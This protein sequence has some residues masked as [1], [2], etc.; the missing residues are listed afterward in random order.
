MIAFEIGSKAIRKR[1]LSAQEEVC[2]QELPKDE[3]EDEA[4]PATGIYQ[5][6]RSVMFQ[7]TKTRKI[8]FV[9]KYNKT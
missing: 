6:Q 1:K 2:L 7:D 3:D 9:V 4:E 5:F 8:R